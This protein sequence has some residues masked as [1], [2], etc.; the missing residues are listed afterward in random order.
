MKK[1][2]IENLKK[3]SVYFLIVLV[4]FL[5]ATALVVSF[6]GVKTANAVGIT[7]Y[8]RS[9]GGNWSA[10]ATWSTTSVLLSN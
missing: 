10:N 9:T 8:A 7:K 4:I 2:I 5:V 3:K 1:I 6:L